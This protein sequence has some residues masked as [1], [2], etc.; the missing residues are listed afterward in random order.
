MHKL[1][2]AVILYINSLPCYKAVQCMYH[3][4][5]SCFIVQSNVSIEKNYHALL[6]TGGLTDQWYPFNTIQ[7]SCDIPRFCYYLIKANQNLGDEFVLPFRTWLRDPKGQTCVLYE[8]RNRLFPP[9]MIKEK[10]LVNF[11]LGLI[12]FYCEVSYLCGGRKVDI[13]NMKFMYTEEH[14]VLVDIGKRNCV[15]TK[16]NEELNDNKAWAHFMNKSKPQPVLI[17]LSKIVPQFFVKRRKKDNLCYLASSLKSSPLTFDD[18]THNVICK[19]A[20]QLS[21]HETLK[22]FIQPN[23]CYKNIVDKMLLRINSHDTL[24][25]R[26]DI[27]Q[28]NPSCI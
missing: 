3:R 28:V 25:P 20:N 12:I 19:S 10:N 14:P 18:Y 17:Y 11:Y 5:K 9:T 16:T 8:M 2:E 15:S 21:L 6:D 26:T 1:M 23:S 4:N 27:L 22:K 7:F 24:I 13:K